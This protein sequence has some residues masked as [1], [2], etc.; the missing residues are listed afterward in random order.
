LTP[1]SG[2]AHWSATTTWQL[3]VVDRPQAG[4]RI[5]S[6][7]GRWLRCGRFGC[8]GISSFRWWAHDAIKATT[9]VGLNQLDDSASV[10]LGVMPIV[11]LAIVAVS[12]PVMPPPV[13]G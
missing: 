6:P 11:E 2:G 3:G 4:V 12:E 9:T 13:V 1:P 10:A 5:E 8:P 7:H